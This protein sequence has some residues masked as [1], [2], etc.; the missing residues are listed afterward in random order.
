MLHMIHI[1]ERLSENDLDSVLTERPHERVR[2]R[3]LP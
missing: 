3:D 2:D 1:A